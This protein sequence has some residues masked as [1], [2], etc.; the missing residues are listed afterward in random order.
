MAWFTLAEVIDSVPL[1]VGFWRYLFSP[2]YRRRKQLEWSEEAIDLKGRALVAAEILGAT[3]FGIGLPV[4]V[5]LI[6][7]WNL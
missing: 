2:D 1:V 3:V 4:L 7:L 5:L 6:V